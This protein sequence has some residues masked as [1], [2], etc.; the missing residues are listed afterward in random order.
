MVRLIKRFRVC[1]ANCL[2]EVCAPKAEG[3]AEEIGIKRGPLPSIIRMK[4]VCVSEG[5]LELVPG[6]SGSLQV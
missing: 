1:P 4:A 3:G 2:K 5:E 6:A